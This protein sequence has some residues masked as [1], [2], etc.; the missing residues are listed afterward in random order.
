MVDVLKII[1]DLPNQLTE[2]YGLGSAFKMPGCSSIFICG[3]GGSALPGDMVSALAEP[4]VP[5]LVIKDYDIPSYAGKDSLVIAISYSGN[6]EETV[7]CFRQ[8]LRIG[9][10]LA[11]IA[12]GGKLKELCEISKIPFIKVPEGFQPRFAYAYQLGAL[13]RLLYNSGYI[14]DPQISE[15][16]E[17]LKK[18]CTKDAKQLAE[19]LNQKIPIIYASTKLRPVAYRWKTQFN[20]NAKSH[21]FYHVF[22]EMNHNEIQG[23]CKLNGPYYVVLIKDE[24]DHPRILKRMQ[25][26]RDFISK[27]GC[28]STE[29]VLKGDNAVARVMSAVLIGDLTSYYL[30]QAYGTDPLDIAVIESLKKELGPW[31]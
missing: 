24:H 8:A 12:S 25:I 18:D 1:L 14:D 2:G 30:S 7:S 17:L 4:K 15:A 9:C 16:A 6:T 23:Y 20:E 27:S 26:T 10:K 5:V 29:I 28:E 13:L 21:A 19:K 11:V 3:M 31:Q 22:P